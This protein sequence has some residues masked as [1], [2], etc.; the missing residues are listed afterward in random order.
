MAAAG[1]EIAE[2]SEGVTAQISTLGE[3]VTAAWIEE[4]DGKGLDGA[5]L[6]ADV[7]RLMEAEMDS[8]STGLSQ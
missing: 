6:V 2:M 8:G 1:N 5:A 7:R 3:T 4:A